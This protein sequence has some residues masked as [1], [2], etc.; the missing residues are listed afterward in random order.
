MAKAI[1]DWFGLVYNH[2]K[3]GALKELVDGEQHL[4]NLMNSGKLR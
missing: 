4:K 3:H 2:D 1:I